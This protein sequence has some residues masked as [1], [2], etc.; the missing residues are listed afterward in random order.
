[1]YTTNPIIVLI[2]TYNPIQNLSNYLDMLHK[3]FDQIIL[4]DNGSEPE[5]R[6]IIEKQ[7]PRRENT[8]KTIFKDCNL[9][10]AMA[11]NQGFDLVITLGYEY[12]IALDQDSLPM[13]GM[14]E[15]MLNIYTAYPKYDKTAIVAPVVEDAKAGFV[16]QYLRSKHP[17]FS[18][19]RIAL[20]RRSKMFQ[21]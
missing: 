8:L 21:L 16:T 5:T 9:R 6:K 14:I 1:M 13:P 2:I 18:N 12:L 15:K 11:L 3:Q 7:I 20:I 4:I 19:E 10:I 17:P